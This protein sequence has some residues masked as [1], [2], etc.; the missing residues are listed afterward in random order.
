M[1]IEHKIGIIAL[2]YGA[3]AFLLVLIITNIDNATWTLLGVMVSMFNYG[4]L[5]TSSKNLKQKTMSLN[6][7]VRY[8]VTLAVLTFAYFRTNQD[9]MILIYV[10]IG[11]FASKIGTLFYFLVF[12]NK[13]HVDVLEDIDDKEVDIS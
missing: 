7:F 3:L 2:I 4:Q 11:L 1:K 6:I 13:E 9:W 12:K 8:G 5:I 10:L